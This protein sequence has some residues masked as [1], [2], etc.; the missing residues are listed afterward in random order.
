MSKATFSRT[1]KL[2]IA[3]NVL[4][5][6]AL[7]L[8]VGGL[9]I[10]LAYRPEVRERVD[11]T[12]GENYT[13]DDKTLKILARLDQDVRLYACFRPLDVTPTGQFVF[14]RALMIETVRRHVDGLLREYELQSDGMLESH[15]YDPQ[16]SG[17][18]GRIRDLMLKLGEP[19]VDIVVVESGERRLVLRIDELAETEVQNNAMRLRKFTAQQAVSSAILAVTEVE[20][21][22]VG[23][24]AGHGERDPESY[25]VDA[26]G[27]GGFAS[28]KR[29]LEQ[30][31][32]MV[33]RIALGRVQ[34]Q[35]SDYDIVVLAAPTEE[36]P[37]EEMRNLA[38]YF[39]GGGNL[40]VMFERETPISLDQPILDEL[41]GLQRRPGVVN[42]AVETRLMTRKRTKFN[43]V[44]HAST[45][46]ITRPLIAKELATYWDGAVGFSTIG[47]P[48]HGHITLRPLARTVDASGAWLDLPDY[49]EEFDPA[50]EQRGLAID[51]AYSAELSRERGGGK[52]VVVG[53][54]DLFDDF[55]L[56]AAPGNRPLVVNAFEWLA[57]REDLISLP[58]RS[59][60]ELRVDLNPKEKE[61]ILLYVVL[62]IPG[63]ALLAALAVFWMRRQ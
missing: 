38:G 18:M 36:L 30:Q 29:D 1:R 13:L 7:A 47:R 56:K 55:N 41:L 42:I 31:N 35:D 62:L 50:T 39:D 24:V 49:N 3:L 26:A 54:S 40:F 57:G 10:Y 53:D 9:L 63:G 46:P 16:T 15:L 6:S 19:A 45:H 59:Y 51:L 43:E 61:T 52:A 17:H 28:V 8:A 20:P 60:D 25:G 21:V 5:S 12:A 23:W 22:R 48:E 2:S 32:Y 33:E 27:R 14:G 4:I 58:P 44:A 11:L 34:L 37:P